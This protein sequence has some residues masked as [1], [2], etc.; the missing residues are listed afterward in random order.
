MLDKK[1]ESMQAYV[2]PKH[3]IVN[4]FDYN[5]ILHFTLLVNN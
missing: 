3:F 4:A 2:K 1:R 5:N